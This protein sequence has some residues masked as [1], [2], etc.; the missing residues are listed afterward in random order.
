MKKLNKGRIIALSLILAVI[1]LSAVGG[2]VAY[3]FDRT[4]S[5]TNSFS[6][7]QVSCL[8]QETFNDGEL[9]KENVSVKNTSDIPA[10]IRAAVVV[11]WTDLT[12]GI[13]AKAPISGVD[14][15]IEFGSGAWERGADGYYYYSVP[16]D[17]GAQTD[18]LIT[19]VR[20]LT[21]KTGYT[22]TVEVLAEAIQSSPAN[23]VTDT[24]GY[25]P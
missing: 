15:V 8:I 11:T 1:A 24:W 10:Y 9:V 17:S 12:G 23:V 25:T 14:Y 20:P 4:E 22:L 3:L 13:S 7:V 16:V 21:Y 18:V 2:T 19:S 6:P 5:V